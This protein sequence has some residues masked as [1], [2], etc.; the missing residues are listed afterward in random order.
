MIN[1]YRR[2]IIIYSVCFVVLGGWLGVR[3]DVLVPVCHAQINGMQYLTPA[4]RICEQ[5]KL[6][7][8]EEEFLPEIVNQQNQP[9]TGFVV[10]RNELNEFGRQAK[11][12]TGNT[13]AN[14]YTWVLFQ[15]IKDPYQILATQSLS[16]LFLFGL[17]VLLICRELNITPTAGLFAAVSGVATPFLVYWLT[18]PMH[19][20]TVCWTAA[21]LYGMMRIFR[22]RDGWGWLVVAFATYGLFMMGYPQTAVYSVWML[23]GYAGVVCWPQLRRGVWWDVARPIGFMASAAVFGALLTIPAYLDLYVRYR[24]S[25]RFWVTDEFFLQ[26]IQSITSVKA[27]LLYVASRFVPELYGN[28]LGT[29][30]PLEFDGANIPLFIGVFLVIAFGY[31]RQVAWWWLTCVGGLWLLTLSPALFTLVLHLFPG[32][33]L[34]AWTPAWSAVLPMALVVAYGCDA[35]LALSRVALR[36][37]LGWVILA[38]VVIV[39][40]GG[41]VAVWFALSIAPWDV[42]RIGLVIA[43]TVGLYW[44]GTPVLLWGALAVN[45]AVTAAPLL[46]LQPRSAL[47]V[48]TPLTQSLHQQVPIGARFAI[49]SAPLEY[50][51]APNYNAMIGVASVHSYN[52]FF[53]PYYQRLINQLGGKITVYGKLNRAIAPNYDDTTFWMSNIAVVLAAQPLDHP[54]LQLV[55]QHDDVWVFHVKQRMGQYWRIPVQQV[56]GV[57]DIHIPDYH[58]PQP[59]PITQHQHRGDVVE[60]HYPVAATQSLVVLSTLYESGWQAESF[61]GHIWKKIVPVSVNGAFL[62][63]VVPAESRA[64]TVRYVTYVQYMWISH[65][66]WLLCFSGVSI[67]YWRDTRRTQK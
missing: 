29:T 56:A 34:S 59:L 58:L 9:H 64:L 44:R 3:G 7:D 17:W 48:T 36:R 5:R 53:T 51:L 37:I 65:L 1:T 66:L 22:Q 67:W 32:F 54:N 42:V 31:R 46:V 12:I 6:A 25:A 14:V 2:A 27:V 62:G 24:D 13:P 20:A 15:L 38:Q 11:H 61:D 30:Y 18:F 26:A 39:G 50:L 57:S 33:R 8:Y 45:I 21:V 28:P 41:I 55:T 43:T 23:V 63:I 52:N 47:I 35:F 49:V 19:I 16:L 40:V 4:M 10:T 60:L